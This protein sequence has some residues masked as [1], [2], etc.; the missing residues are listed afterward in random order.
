M[1]VIATKA[2]EELKVKAVETNSIP[3]EGEE[4]EIKNEKFAYLNGNN[5]YKAIF[6]KKA[7]KEEKTEKDKDIEDILKT[8]KKKK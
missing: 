1:K 7:E 8:E 2:Y 4:F 5:P 3:K 6:V